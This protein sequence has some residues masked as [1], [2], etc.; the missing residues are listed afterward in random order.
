MIRKAKSN[1]EEIA[2]HN[3]QEIDEVLALFLTAVLGDHKNMKVAQHV[4]VN[5][6][7]ETP[8]LVATNAAGLF[9]VSQHKSV[10]KS[11]ACMTAKGIMIVY[12]SPLVYITIANFG[13]AH[14]HLPNT[15]K[16]VSSRRSL[17]T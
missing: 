11:H 6:L 12:P 3:R 5:A 15:E 17:R 14:A 16:S 2:P 9:A 8:V 13:R 7:C 10:A 4:V 1:V